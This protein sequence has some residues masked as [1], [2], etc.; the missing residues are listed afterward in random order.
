M[1]AHTGTNKGT[2]T[3]AYLYTV[4]R[5]VCPGLAVYTALQSSENAKRMALR[6]VVRVGAKLTER[7]GARGWGWYHK[8]LKEQASPALPLAYPQAETDA[9]RTRAY[10]DVTMEETK[11]T[12]RIVFE[13]A[14]RW[15]AEQTHA[16]C[17]H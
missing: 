12:N 13:L 17:N 1:R 4:A 8:A 7:R 15:I 11:T 3:Y 6:R 9:E 14:V 2:R 10:F 5:A 16:L